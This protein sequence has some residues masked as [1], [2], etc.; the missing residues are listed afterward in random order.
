MSPDDRRQA[1]ETLRL[2]G[3]GIPRCTVASALASTRPCAGEGATADLP[4][5]ATCLFAISKGTLKARD[6]A[7]S[8][9]NQPK[10]TLGFLA[11]Q[12]GHAGSIP[13]TRSTL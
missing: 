10:Q 5:N 6:A 8:S 12:A 1:R 11:L 4:N 2:D 9:L 7:K 13:V 3:H